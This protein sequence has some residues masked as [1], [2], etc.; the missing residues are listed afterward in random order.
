MPDEPNQS[1]SPSFEQSLDALSSI[2]HD[3]E[4]GQV[5]LAESLA[6]YEQGVKLLRECY[7]LLQKAERRIE[8]LTRVEPSGDPVTEPFDDSPSAQS[9]SDIAQPSATR[10]RRRSTKSTQKGLTDIETPNSGGDSGEI[11]VPGGLF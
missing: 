6:K 10:S 8:L 3:L 4:E 5:G 7:E 1:Q 11:D 2:V 9:P